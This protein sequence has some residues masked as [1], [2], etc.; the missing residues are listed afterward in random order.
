M[1]KVKNIFL[2]EFKS[3]PF[4]YVV[5]AVSII[6]ILLNLWLVNK[7]SPLAKNIDAVIN[8]VN[9]METN[10]AELQDVSKSNQ[11]IVIKLEALTVSLSEVKSRIERIDNRLAKHM[12]I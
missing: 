5:Q 1:P 6:V 10:I 9:A 3:R 4:G 12:G 2:Q 8:R 7:L 11:E